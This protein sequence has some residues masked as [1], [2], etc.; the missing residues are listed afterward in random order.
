MSCEIR[1]ITIINS[2]HKE[3]CFQTTGKWL[4]KYG[5]PIGTK[6]EVLPSNNM[7]IITKLPDYLNLEEDRNRFNKITSLRDELS[8]FDNN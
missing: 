7:L 6:I 3:P 2:S 5:F 4:E 1:R 8:R